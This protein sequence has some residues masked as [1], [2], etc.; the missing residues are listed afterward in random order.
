MCSSDGA[1][2][3]ELRA[4]TLPDGE[5]VIHSTR[6]EAVTPGVTANAFIVSVKLPGEPERFCTHLEIG[7]GMV[8]EFD[9]MVGRLASVSGG[10]TEREGPVIIVHFSNESYREALADLFGL[11]PDI[12]L[13]VVGKAQELY[14]E[15]E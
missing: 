11:V 9:A 3:I 6:L 5:C 13:Q 2:A 1:P 12:V 7:S 14:A 15:P 10:R 4:C 8:S